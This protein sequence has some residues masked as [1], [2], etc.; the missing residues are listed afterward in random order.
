VRPAVS[1]ARVREAILRRFGSGLLG[2]VSMVGIGA[3]AMRVAATVK[4]LVVAHRFGTSDA[5]DAYLL[6]FA[7]P[8]FLAGSFRS[9]FYSAFVPRFLE[10]ETRGGD[11]LASDYLR[12]ALLTHL[13]L[14]VVLAAALALSAS[15]VVSLIGH[16]FP[17][18]KREM[19]V[20]LVVALAPFIILDGAA[21]IYS[22]A[23]NARGRFVIAAS[24][25]T[26][27]PLVTLVA[28]VTLARTIGVYALVGGAVVGAALEAGVAA[29]LVRR[30]GLRVAPALVRPG[31]DGTALLRAFAILAG[32]GALMSANAVVDQ[33]MATAAGAGSVAALGF[34][35]KI[36]AAVL[37]LAG[38][39]LGTTMLPHYAEF[40]AGRRWDAMALALRRHAVRVGFAGLA[41]AVAL[42]AVSVPL[43]RVLFQHGSFGPADTARVA[44]IQSFYALQIPGFLIGIVAARFLN[45]LGRDRWI[46]AVSASNFVLNVAGNWILL[47]WFGL[48]GIA[49]S[50][51]VFY[52]VSAGLLLVLCRRALDER[53]RAQTP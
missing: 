22:A 46:L 43:V 28:V 52:T 26:I 49:L 35:A 20:R 30:E 24:V 23:L 10:A 33:A 50:T 1:P 41:F 34:G 27:P 17:P 39:A 31:P 19:T 12:R 5:L 29:A 42:A 14:L 40:A 2:T 11:P 9:A 51:A 13:A 32:G 7:V 16:A 48:P 6:A 25:A 18:E 4:D 37:G 36:P 44:G 47:R 8:V 3:A 38:V 15:P 45:A 53:R 21:G